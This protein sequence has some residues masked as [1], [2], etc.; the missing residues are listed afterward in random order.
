MQIFFLF[1]IALEEGHIE[2]TS[3]ITH[4]QL[5]S[6]Q[7]GARLPIQLSNFAETVD[8]STYIF[9]AYTIRSPEKITNVRALYYTP[10][11]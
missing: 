10:W 2:K 11:R 5:V 1:V 9:A 3:Y 8:V 6:T 4:A 7:T